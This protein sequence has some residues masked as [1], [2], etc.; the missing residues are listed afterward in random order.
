VGLYETT[1][2]RSFALPDGVYI[3][4]LGFQIPNTHPVQPRGS[5]I[6]LAQESLNL[7]RMEF[8][9]LGEP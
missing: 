8:Q 6:N 9:R 1:P 2:V 7:C 5:R 4:S 3:F